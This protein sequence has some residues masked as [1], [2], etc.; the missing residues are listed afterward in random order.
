M[1][2]WFKVKYKYESVVMKR[3][4]LLLVLAILAVSCN[5]VEISDQVETD[6]IPPVTV[7]LTKAQEAVAAGQIKFD[8]EFFKKT[9]ESAEGNMVVSPFSMAAA[10]SMASAGAAGDTYSEIAATLGFKD[11]TSSE[12]GAFYSKSLEA[13]QPSSDNAKLSVAN[14]IWV[15]KRS[16]LKDGFVS[17]VENSYSAEVAS[18]DLTDL[19]SI[20]YINDWVKDKTGGMV[21]RLIDESAKNAAMIL[22]NAV[23]FDAKWLASFDVKDIEFTDIDGIKAERPFFYGSFTAA[24]KVYNLENGENYDASEPQAICLHYFKDSP[25][26]MVFVLPPKDIAINDYIAGLNDSKWNSLMSS[27]STP[28]MSTKLYIPEFKA[29]ASVED[30]KS[31]LSEMGIH[32]AF[33]NDPDFS[34]ALDDPVGVS[35]IFHKADIDVSH[36]GVRAAAASAL[37]FD[38]TSTGAQV[39]YQI[40]KADRPFVYAIIEPTTQSILFM[41]V[42][43]K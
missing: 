31:I 7:G 12:I 20:D 18:L 28:R 16:A 13:M 27:L 35:Q 39:Q 38:F 9:A 6:S 14:A 5:K 40:F 41:G 36:E 23:F 3:L 29:A 37:V 17:D 42:L 26:E 15:D 34:K 2:V 4:F 30:P 25:L 8:I 43:R 21:E 32:K 22:T 1:D 19:K 10:W 24:A 33:S 11:C